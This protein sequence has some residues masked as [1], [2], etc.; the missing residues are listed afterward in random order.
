MT[1]FQKKDFLTNQPY[2]LYD[3]VS[4][5][6]K[7]QTISHFALSD[8]LTT[9]IGKQQNK[10]AIH[11]WS[12]DPLVIL[13]MMDTKLP[14]LSDGLAVLKVNNQPYI[15]RNSGGLAVASDSGVLNFSLIFPE[16]AANRIT[17]DE[18][19]DFMYRLVSETLKDYNKKIEAYEISDSYCPGDFDLSINGKKIAG[20]AQRRLKNG[21]AIMIYLSVTGNQN[22]RAQLL[23]DF[24]AAGVQNKQ[25]KWHFPK[26][27]PEVMGTLEELLDAQLTIQDVKEKIVQTLRKRDCIIEPGEYSSEILHLYEDS[28]QKM[29]DRNLQMLKENAQKELLI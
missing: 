20:I 19:Y 7:N 18:G 6:F 9:V 1:S 29:I 26:I 3:A 23:Q 28:K 12:T 15:V 22:K 25:V 27:D 14:Y 13:G 21:V 5:P 16:E 24:Y 17:I 2:A 4:M 10:A 11:F 8:S